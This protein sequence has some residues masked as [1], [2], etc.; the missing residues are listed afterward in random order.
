MSD[1]FSIER[2][3]SPPPILWF[4]FVVLFLLAGWLYL[5]AARRH[6]VPPE[7]SGIVTF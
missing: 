5:G 1:R 2:N 3:W 7:T 6:P 4:A